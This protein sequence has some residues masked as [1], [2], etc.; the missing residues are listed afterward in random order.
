MKIT[1]RRRIAVEAGGALVVLGAIVGAVVTFAG[2]PK[3]P[4]GPTEGSPEWIQAY[5]AKVKRS[6]D[7]GRVHGILIRSRAQEVTDVLCA[8]EWGKLTDEQRRG[9][10]ESAF[11]GG[12]RMSP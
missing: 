11:A 12:C 4:A 6:A 1:G 10:D 8:V 2:D 9:L 7:L 5:D 3:P